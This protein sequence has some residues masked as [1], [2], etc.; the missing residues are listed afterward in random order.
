MGMRKLFSKWV[1]RLLTPEQKQ[2][3]VKNSDKDRR[4][5]PS[6]L[7]FALTEFPDCGCHLQS[8]LWL[9]DSICNISMP[10]TQHL[11]GKVMAS[12]FWDAHGILFIDYLEKGKTINS[13]YH[14]ALLDRLSTEIKKKRP[15]MERKKVLFHQ[16]NAPC[17]RFMKTMVK[18][19]ELSFELL[20]RPPYSP[21]L[22]PS[23]YWLFVDVKTILQEQRFGSNEEVMPKLWPVLRT[24]MN[25]STKKASKI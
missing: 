2:K 14:M 20:P 12:V 6:S 1:P 23:D 3:R 4:N 21:D 8:G 19:N 13:E 10:K 18:L 17:H 22:V 25:H 24:K 7:S 5:L 11:V 15:H 9:V 16:E